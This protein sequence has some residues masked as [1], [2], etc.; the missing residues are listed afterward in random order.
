VEWVTIGS[1]AVV[2]G[3]RM[4]VEEVGLVVTLA[5]PLEILFQPVLKQPLVFSSL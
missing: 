2:L 4:P 1:E 5:G 3:E